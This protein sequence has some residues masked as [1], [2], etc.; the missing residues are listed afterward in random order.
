M[1]KKHQGAPSDVIA[2]A[3]LSDP[4]RTERRMR[5]EVKLKPGHPSGVYRRGGMQFHRT[6]PAF[7]EDR[8]EP[9][10]S[11]PWL[12]VAAEPTEIEWE[13]DDEVPDPGQQP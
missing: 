1:P 8:V 4:Q 9:F 12:I 5:Y 7:I 11:D 6:A 13:I 3:V 2:D 10:V